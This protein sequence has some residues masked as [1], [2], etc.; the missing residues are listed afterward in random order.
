MGNISTGAYVDAVGYMLLS[1]NS[2]VGWIGKPSG[3]GAAAPLKNT[4][5][6]AN[7]MSSSLLL[8]GYPARNHYRLYMQCNK[9]LQLHLAALKIACT[10]PLQ[11]FCVP[12]RTLD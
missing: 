10:Q 7:V 8:S 1:S 3:G 6:S 4:T 9:Y 12:L 5:M 11:W 2:K